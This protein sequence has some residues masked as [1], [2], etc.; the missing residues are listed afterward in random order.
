MLVFLPGFA[1][2]IKFRLL[3][4][5]A[6]GSLI[7]YGASFYL[8]LLPLST[9]LLTGG[10][11]KVHQSIR[12]CGPGPL[13]LPDMSCSGPLHPLDMVRKVQCTKCI[14]SDRACL[15]GALDHGYVTLHV[16]FYCEAMQSTTTTTDSYVQAELITRDEFL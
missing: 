13:D 8:L 11:Y 6:T 12:P 15:V 16:L 2:T 5:G 9:L 10:N 1:H 7:D 14:W 4:P 3:F